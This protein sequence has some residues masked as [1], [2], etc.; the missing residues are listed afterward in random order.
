MNSISLWN[1]KVHDLYKSLSLDNSYRNSQQDATVYQNLLF[2]VYMKLNMFWVTHRP[3]SGAQNCT[4]SL[5]FCMCE[6]LLDAVSVQQPQQPT[7]HVCKTRGCLCS[8][9]LL[10]MGGVSPKTCWASYKHGIINSDILLH[11]VGYSCMNYTM[12]HGSTNIL[13][14]IL[15]W[16]V[17]F[18]WNTTH[19]FK[20]SFN[21]I[22]LLIT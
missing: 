15:F 18:P 14:W 10:M 1:L 13:H 7:F 11:L 19:F 3:S 8:F 17:K 12:M 16:T 21:I 5:W 9:E 2:H 20:I 4:S 6:R 22:I